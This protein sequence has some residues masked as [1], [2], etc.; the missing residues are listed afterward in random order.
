MRAVRDM[1]YGQDTATGQHAVTPTD[2]RPLLPQTHLILLSQGKE[3]TVDFRPENIYAQGFVF[4]PVFAVGEL[5]FLCLFAESGLDQ[6][7]P[8]FAS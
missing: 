8:V 5:K 2:M 7:R 1:S 6:Y 3:I 4:I